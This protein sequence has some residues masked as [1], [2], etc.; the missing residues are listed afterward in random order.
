VAFAL[1]DSVRFEIRPLSGESFKGCQAL[2]RESLP[3]DHSGVIS[4]AV[5]FAI[6]IAAYLL[7]PSTAAATTLIAAGAIMT[8]IL[9]SR[10]H[11]KARLAQVRAADKHS[12]ETHFVELDDTGARTWCAH[13][14]ARFPW[15]DFTRT[16]ESA[17]FFLLIRPGGAGIAIPKRVVGTGAAELRERLSVWL[18]RPIASPKPELPGGGT[19]AN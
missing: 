1:S 16:T 18:A 17:E 7:T 5:C 12:L 3:P 8:L 15:H 13:V 9:A 19:Q 2:A 4:F 11:A 6:P 10:A 14:D